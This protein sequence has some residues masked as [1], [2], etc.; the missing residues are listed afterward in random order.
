MLPNLGLID[1][2]IEIGSPRAHDGHMRKEGISEKS[3]RVFKKSSILYSMPYNDNVH[4]DFVT[5][6]QDDEFDLWP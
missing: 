2:Y 4:L 3:S 6:L 5:H 1:S